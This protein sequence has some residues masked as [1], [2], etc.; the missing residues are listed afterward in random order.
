MTNFKKGMSPYL[1]TY[2]LRYVLGQST[3]L[4]NMITNISFGILYISHGTTLF[5][6][7][8]CNKLLRKVLIEYFSY[9]KIN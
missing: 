4:L 1:I 3:P 9:F 7:L 8:S 6:Y 2:I 5:I